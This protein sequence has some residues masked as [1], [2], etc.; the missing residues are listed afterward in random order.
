MVFMRTATVS[1]FVHHC[2][3]MNCV[4]YFPKT[5]RI[6][7]CTCSASLIE[8]IP[9]VNAH[10][11]STP[12]PYGTGVS[13][14]DSNLPSNVN[15]LNGDT[16]NHPFTPIPPSTNANP[17]YPYG[18]ALIFT[19]TPQPVIQ[20]DITQIDAYSHSEAGGSYG[21][22][23]QDNLSVNVQGSSESARFI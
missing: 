10:R 18:N 3:A 19:P 5:A 20:M 13:I 23:Y 7:A 17:S 2:P 1:M 11:S 16:T 4:A 8:H 14:H 9:V 21:A 15:T 12:L 22:Q 6:Q